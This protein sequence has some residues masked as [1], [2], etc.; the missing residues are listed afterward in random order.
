M[1]KSIKYISLLLLSIVIILIIIIFY[2]Y[3]I[4]YFNYNAIYEKNI[5]SDQIFHKIKSICNK[6]STNDMVIDPKAHKR[7]MYVFNPYDSDP[8]NHEIYSLIYNENVM[9]KIRN[10]TGVYDLKPCLQIP[11]EYRKYLIGS[12]MDWHRDFQILPEN[13]LQYECVLTLSNNSDS[14][15]LLDKIIYTSSIS[16]E[17]NSLVIVRAKGINHMVTKTTQGERTIIKFIA[18]RF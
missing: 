8:I 3:N 14:K 11:I 7:I 12:Y 15:T 1:N 9:Q 16:T 6:I 2:E 17:P 13:N 4:N 18:C 5:Y 10:L